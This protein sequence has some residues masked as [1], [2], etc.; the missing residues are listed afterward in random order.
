MKSC[1]RRGGIAW[2][3]LLAATTGALSDEL[4]S[5]Y[6]FDRPPFVN[7]R[8]VEDL[9]TWLSDS[10]DQVVA[11]NLTASQ[12]SNRYFGDVLVRE[13]PDEHPFVFHED[14]AAGFGY[15]FVGTT[16]SGL[17]VLA[18]SEWGGGSGV[19]RRVLLVRFEADAGLTVDWDAGR[20]ATSTEPRL[21]LWKSGEIGLGDRW[22]GELRVEGDTLV[23]GTDEGWFAA[24]GGLGGGPLSEEPR[25]RHLRIESERE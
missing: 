1:L 3:A 16:P 2:L 17:H 23:I 9:T 12:D 18:T 15:S 21:L 5:P 19:F 10:S 8:I 25:E 20:V 7:P 4:A 22:D 24:S 6:H 13:E 11:V 14:G